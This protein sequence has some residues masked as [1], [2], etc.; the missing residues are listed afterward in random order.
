MSTMQAAVVREF[1]EKLDVSQIDVPRPGPGQ[2]LVRLVA[3]GVCHTD[4]HA[5]EGDWPVK[6][7]PPFVPGQ[8][9]ATTRP[10]EDG[11]ALIAAATCA[12]VLVSSP[13]G[14]VASTTTR[15]RPDI[16]TMSG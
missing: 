15:S 5:A 14:P 8:T 10:A 3:S 1:G 6:P 11:F 16:D 12:A 2:A 7:Q 13:L 9:C 4:L